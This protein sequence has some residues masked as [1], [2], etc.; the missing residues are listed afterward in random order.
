ME[1]RPVLTSLP[2]LAVETVRAIDSPTAG[3][4]A[5]YSQCNEKEAESNHCFLFLLADMIDIDH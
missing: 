2:L 4:Y 5:E 1:A 3:S